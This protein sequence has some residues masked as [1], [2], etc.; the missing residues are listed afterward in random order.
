MKKK[1]GEIYNT[2]IVVGD[3]NLKTKN[4]IHIDE[5][6]NTQSG[7]GSVMEYLDITNIDAAIKSEIISYSYLLKYNLG[8]YPVAFVLAMGG[9]LSQLAPVVTAVAVYSAAK[10]VA[11]EHSGTIGDFLAVVAG[12]VPRITE[13]EFYNTDVPE[14]EE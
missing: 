13:E 6:N 14:V 3:K 9:S 5:L 2:P 12:N 11:G 4:E 1:I 7:G 10:V 8:V